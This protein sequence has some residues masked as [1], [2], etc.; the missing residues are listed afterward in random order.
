[1]SKKTRKIKKRYWLLTILIL[2]FLMDTYI[3]WEFL[4]FKHRQEVSLLL[5]ETAHEWRL[6]PQFFRV[7][8]YTEQRMEIFMVEEGGQDMWVEF[9]KDTQGEWQET[10]SSWCTTANG[11][12]RCFSLWYSL[13][14]IQQFLEGN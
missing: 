14:G 12:A 6:K 8:L 2:I 7:F 3:K 4:T 10:R 5:N 13:R 11:S 1:M 9:E